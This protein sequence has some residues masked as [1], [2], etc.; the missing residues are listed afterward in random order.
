MNMIEVSHGIATHKGGTM[1][2]V[3]VEYDDYCDF[4]SALPQLMSHLKASVLREAT[5]DASSQIQEP[6]HG[7][8][9]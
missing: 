6:G 7:N 1:V 4:C 5:K 2:K 9:L 8:T 3:I